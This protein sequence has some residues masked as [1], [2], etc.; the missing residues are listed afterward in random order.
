MDAQRQAVLLVDQA[1]ELIQAGDYDAAEAR[2]AQAM[3]I[4]P[5]LPEA[6]EVQR[7]V[8]E[9]RLALPASSLVSRI[10]Q[11]NRLQWDLAVRK[12]RD[13]EQ[14]ILAMSTTTTSTRPAASCCRPAR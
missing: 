2:L 5:N 13:L 6:V 7:R 3:R 9:A 10:R 4:V 1:R 14:Q 12:Y 8:G 11:T